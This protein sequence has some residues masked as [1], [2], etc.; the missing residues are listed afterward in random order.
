ML[1]VQLESSV[2]QDSLVFLLS[3]W[4]MMKLRE[5]LFVKEFMQMYRM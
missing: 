4:I 2:S 5:S 1:T 3:S